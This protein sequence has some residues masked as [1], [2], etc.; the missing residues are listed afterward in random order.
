MNATLTYPAS[1]HA[2]S[3]TPGKI[4]RRA[5]LIGEHN[6]EV[7]GKELRISKSQMAL[8]KQAGVI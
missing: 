8:L 4:K 6:D 5:P 3:L 7:Y 1:F 2:L